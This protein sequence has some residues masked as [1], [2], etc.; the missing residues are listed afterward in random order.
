MT[1]AEFVQIHCPGEISPESMTCQFDHI[2]PA[3]IRQDDSGPG[4]TT[5]QEFQ[6]SHCKFRKTLLRGILQIMNQAPDALRQIRHI[7]Q[8]L[9]RAFRMDDPHGAQ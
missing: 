5:P 4:L 9:D 1:G 8:L 2:F 3:L 7:A 6:H